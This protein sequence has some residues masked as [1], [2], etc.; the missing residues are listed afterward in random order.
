M[1][2]ESYTIGGELIH[3]AKGNEWS[4]HRYIDKVKTKSGKWRYI[5]KDTS[6]N[7][8]SRK[9]SKGFDNTANK[10]TITQINSRYE[11]LRKKDPIAADQYL[12]SMAKKYS[13]TRIGEW[14]NNKFRSTLGTESPKMSLDQEKANYEI[15]KGRRQVEDNKWKREELR[16]KNIS[17]QQD[18]NFV[19]VETVTKP[20]VSEEYKKEL[21]YNS[22]KNKYPEEYERIKKDIDNTKK[23]IEKAKKDMEEKQKNNKPYEEMFKETMGETVE[24][25]NEKKKEAN[26]RINKI[27][28]F[29]DP[30]IDKLTKK[31][32]KKK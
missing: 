29:V 16:L 9:Q 27:N 23:D 2:Y 10:T 11:Y 6:S 7:K 18:K 20:Y 14:V 24:E 19:K 3:S 25:F 32:K 12:K 1:L 22:K 13:G 28:S 8:Y 30:I 17:D 21:E 5:Y 4:K 31:K 15:A 26:D